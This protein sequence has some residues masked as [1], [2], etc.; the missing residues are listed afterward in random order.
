M[1]IDLA[2]QR[3]EAHLL[4]DIVPEEKLGEVR[5]LLNAL[6]DPME[7]LH[8]TASYDEEALSLEAIASMQRGRLDIENG[9]VTSQEDMLKEFGV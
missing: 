5:N 7:Y 4:L 3:Q 1:A 8:A 6:I 2:Q 9:E